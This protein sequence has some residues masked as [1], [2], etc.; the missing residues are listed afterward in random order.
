MGGDKFSTDFITDFI[1]PL[2]TSNIGPHVHSPR[3]AQVTNYSY[4]CFHPGQEIPIRIKSGGW[5]HRGA[6]VCP[7]C[8]EVCGAE[9]ELNNQTCKLGEE[10]PPSNV[11]HKDELTC[12]ADHRAHANGRLLRLSVFASIVATFVVSVRI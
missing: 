9:F 2:I 12:A 6:I 3:T 10:A 4:E 11:F 5:L 7:T 1:C 8:H